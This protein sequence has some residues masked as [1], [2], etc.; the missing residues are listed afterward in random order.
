MAVAAGVGLGGCASQPAEA[1]YDLTISR[2]GKPWAEAA[3]LVQP[4][5]RRNLPVNP[6]QLGPVVDYLSRPAPLTTV[7]GR[8]DADG[9]IRVRLIESFTTKLYIQGV[10]TTPIS[11]LLEPYEDSATDGSWLL[12]P[13]VE[14]EVGEPPVIVQIRPAG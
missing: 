11:I 12:R 1:D 8:T 2:G 4:F 10:G 7:A 5:D 13:V 6:I 14:P 9:H 3:V